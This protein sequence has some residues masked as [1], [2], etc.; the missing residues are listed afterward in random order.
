MLDTKASI[1]SEQHSRYDCYI[2]VR[3]VGE[4]NLERSVSCKGEKCQPLSSVPKRRAVL[5]TVKLWSVLALNTQRWSH[6]GD[7]GNKEGWQV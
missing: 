2:S 3:H 5:G 4:D 7:T 6:T 1:L